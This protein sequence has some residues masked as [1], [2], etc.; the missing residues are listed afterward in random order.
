MTKQSLNEE[1][2]VL[3]RRLRHLETSQANAA[4]EDP[5]L[6]A[7]APAQGQHGKAMSA[8]D[9][10]ATQPSGSSPSPGK[11][12]WRRGQGKQLSAHDKIGMLAELST[13]DE[14][15]L[16]RWSQSKDKV[17]SPNGAPAQPSPVP[18][19]RGREAQ[20][21]FTEKDKRALAMWGS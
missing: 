7:T 9:L 5:A 11:A 12:E 13:A 4:Q 19:M 14:L 10:L 16:E 17:A 6:Q 2:L 3:T 20:K 15:A 1:N 21:A 18:F 8:E